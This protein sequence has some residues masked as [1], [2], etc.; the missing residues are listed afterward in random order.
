MLL[1]FMLDFGQLFMIK[2]EV[3]PE[4]QEW[5]LHQGNPWLPHKQN[6]LWSSSEG[7]EPQRLEK[8][9][10]KIPFTAEAVKS[11]D[12]ERK[13]TSHKQ[14]G[15]NRVHCEKSKSTRTFGPSSRLLQ[16][17][18]DKTFSSDTENSD[19]YLQKTPQSCLVALSFKEDSVSHRG[20]N[21]MD[22][23]VD[24]VQNV[25]IN[26]EESDLKRPIQLRMGKKTFTCVFC[27]KEF[28]KKAFLKKHASNHTRQ[29]TCSCSFCGKG[30]SEKTDLTKHIR[31]HTVKKLFSCSTCGKIFSQNESLRR[32]QRIHS[33]EKPFSCPVCTKQFIHRG[34]MVIHMRIHT[35]EKPFGCSICGKRYSETGN[36]KKHMRVHAGEKPSRVYELKM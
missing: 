15:T 29:K 2:Q 9:G 1:S 4:Q 26:T 11:E 30:F 31:V 10:N 8:D 25:N 7:K 33:G 19:D 24:G 14:T 17:C 18:N 16:E 5:S 22:K 6:Q 34:V 21:L 13:A 20:S 27:K 28:T 32:H 3:L 23:Q 12:C 36:M 35:G